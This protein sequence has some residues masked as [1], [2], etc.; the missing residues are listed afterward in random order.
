MK[1]S[2]RVQR[3][4]P[5]ATLA[6]TAKTAELREMGI[7]VIDLGAGEPDFNTP[8]SIIDAAFE[9]AKAGKTKYT[10][11]GGVK[12]LKALIRKK[13]L[14]DQ[15]LDYPS[16]EII[17]TD[18]AKH[19]LYLLFQTILNP[20][21]EVLIPVPYWVSYP[22]QVKLA[23]GIPVFVPTEEKNNFKLSPKMLQPVLTERTKA[24]VLNSPSNPTGMIYT[25][26][27]LRKIGEICLERNLWIISD[28]IYEKLIYGGNRH[29]SIAT[30]GE[31]WKKQT[32]VING[33]SKSHAMTGWRIGYAAGDREVI[34]AMTALASHS[35]S[36]PATPSQYAAIAALD[37]GQQ[38][39]EQ[40]RKIFE[41][42]L[43][44]AY[45][46]IRNIP[47]FQCRK[48]QGA[49]YLFPRVKEAADR[50][51][52]RTI[53]D[54]AA[55]LLERAHVAVVPGRGFGMPEYIRISYATGEDLLE[56]ALLRIREFVENGGR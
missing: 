9:A 47:G 38:E 11:S 28:E 20:G 55:A 34:Q 49:F 4:S 8:S 1:L 51:G 14:R 42:R 32:I 54:F 12:P 31:E 56:K 2:E 24:I 22:E 19:A 40:M 27:E 35:T 16:D 33:L 6:I 46:L 52:F 45:Q 53:D 48:P 39:V 17:V 26:E 36:N 7:E 3:L 13:F 10:A 37:G 5:S 41:R 23:G 44:L 15:G 21:D 30:L 50:L 25:R 18:G 29:I 43:E